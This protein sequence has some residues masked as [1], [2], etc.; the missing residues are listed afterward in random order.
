[1]LATQVLCC[2]VP[3]HFALVI[4]DMGVLKLFALAG[5]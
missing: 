5:L 1:M 4:L 2:F 3:V